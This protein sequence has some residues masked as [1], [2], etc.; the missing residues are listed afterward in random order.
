[1]WTGTN[2]DAYVPCTALQEELSRLRTWVQGA[3][4]QTSL[5]RPLFNI[6]YYEDHDL[7]NAHLSVLQAI[8]IPGSNPD[9]ASTRQR[10]PLAKLGPRIELIR[11]RMN[12]DTMQ[13]LPSLPHWPGYIDLTTCTWPLVDVTLYKELAQY[14]PTSYVGW[15][16]GLDRSHQAMLASI[17]A[18]IDEQRGALGLTELKVCVGKGANSGHSWE[19]VAVVRNM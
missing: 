3:Q 4:W 18:G 13:L 2:D 11:W 7:V 8:K 1:M 17:C 9:L 10:R 16:L 12:H 14:I 19:R 6:A 5:S 15:Y